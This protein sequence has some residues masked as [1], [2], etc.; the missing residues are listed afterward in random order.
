MVTAAM[1]APLTRGHS[2]A[3]LGDQLMHEQRLR[4][5]LHRLCASGWEERLAPLARHMAERHLVRA[6]SE[7]G[8]PLRRLDLETLRDALTGLLMPDDDDDDDDDD[9]WLIYRLIVEG[10]EPAQV[11]AERG[12]D[13]AELVDLLREAV[14][15]LAIQY[16]DVANAHLDEAPMV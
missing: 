6:R 8:S 1:S 12:I 5:A 16:E 2:P 10:A 13:E 15:S 3:P 7:D 14:E 11:A 9:G 4:T